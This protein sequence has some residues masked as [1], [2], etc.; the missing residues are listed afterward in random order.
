MNIIL[1]GIQGSGKSTQGNL[2]SE[3]LGI[4]YLSAGHIFRILSKQKTPLGH[5]IKVVMNAGFLIPNEK[6]LK[7]VEDYLE[8]PEYKNGFILDGFPRTLVQAKKFRIRVDKAIY[9]KISDK[10]A[11]WRISGRE[12]IRED[13][14]LMAIR[15]RIEMFHKFTE[16]VLEYYRSNGVLIEVDGERPVIDISEDILSK[17][18]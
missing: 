10:E 7:I 11:L 1:I 13:E 12:E 5:Q 8:K 15:K 17:I 9:I 6:T 3:K 2:L 16:P 18:D 14:T 4:P